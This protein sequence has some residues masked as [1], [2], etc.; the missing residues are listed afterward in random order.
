MDTSW[1]SLQAADDPVRSSF[2]QFTHTL[3]ALHMRPI[4]L[5]LTLLTI[6][7]AFSSTAQPF[8]VQLTGT[9]P[10]CAPNSV[11]E[12]YEEPGLLLDVVALD[13][14][15]SFSSTFGVF[16]PIGTLNF[17]GSCANGSQAF[18]LV[19]FEFAQPGDT[20][21][22][23]IPLFCGGD[24]VDC[25]GVTG[26]TALPGH[27][28]DDGSAST[29]LDTWTSDCLCAGLDSSQVVFDC[30][31]IP[32]GHNLPGTPCLLDDPTAPFPV[33]L[34]S[35]DCQCLPDS[36]FGSYTDCLGAVNG[37]AVSGTPCDDGN[38]STAIDLWDV[39]CQCVGYDSTAVVFDCQGVPFGGALPGSPCLIDSLPFF[40]IGIWDSNCS[41]I[42]DTT[43]GAFDCLGIQGGGN[44]PGTPC[45]TG[46]FGL[47]EGFWSSSCECVPDS[48]QILYFDCTGLPNGP[49]VA[50]A[51]CSFTADGVN[52]GPG[53]WN[54][55]CVCIADTSAGPL[56][57]AGLPNGPNQPGTP[58]F[59]P[60]N[61]FGIGF[62]DLSCTCIVDTTNAPLD[63]LGIPGGP[64]MPGLPC[65][66]LPD[67][68]NTV[69]GIWGA[70]CICYANTFD[71]LGIPGGGNVPGTPC[72]SIALDGSP[73][74]GIWGPDC[75]CYGDSSTFVLD[76]LG[77][78]NGPNMPGTQCI[79]FN[80]FPFAPIGTW[81]LDCQCLPDS[82]YFYTDCLGIENGP[83]TISSVCDTGDPNVLGYWNSD[84]VC[85]AYTMPPCTAGFIVTPGIIDTAGV[86]PMM[87]WIW[88]TSFGGTGVYSYLWDFGDGST[89]T[90]PWPLHDYEGTGPYVLCLTITDS[91][92]CSDTFCDTLA[93]DEN[94]GFNG[95][96]EGNDRSGGFSIQVQAGQLATSV[97]EIAEVETLEL[98]PNPTSD[99][100]TLR[101]SGDGVRATE[102]LVMDLE[103]RVVLEQREGGQGNGTF[104]VNVA[105]LEAGAYVV[106]ISAEGRIATARFMRVY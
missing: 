95:L 82:S 90:D 59:D 58:C 67:S 79:P 64:N 68:S 102:I 94:G 91:D 11:V 104:E 10:T 18:N 78:P 56:D 73:Y 96:A 69:V 13:G 106:R 66:L 14:N 63:C 19:N 17:V 88:N 38:A 45:F 16:Q 37:P 2:L 6:A 84:C 53:I 31:G 60:T 36:T 52:F 47:P 15:C 1:F 54:T 48:A 25:L 101:W 39:N 23:N 8:T 99:R 97:N 89:S 71:C 4:R 24:Q 22:L 27:P 77:Q 34:W 30:A 7:L 28:C 86:D 46:I 26:G 61:P 5:L 12:I 20:I 76:C 43:F 51:S 42:P 32:N 35:A 57:C 85:E 49:N 33:G 83:N 65:S 50:G 93:V 62:W 41:C 81:T 98:W 100:I 80:E 72:Q 74:E 3:N 55:D 40:S 87:L 9:V 75:F 103:G 44:L 29:V 92:G 21:F 105:Q 70:D